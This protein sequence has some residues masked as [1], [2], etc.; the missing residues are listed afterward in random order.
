MLHKLTFTFL[1]FSKLMPLGISAKNGAEVKYSYMDS[2][3]DFGAGGSGGGFCGLR[4]MEF[5]FRVSVDFLGGG[6][7]CWGIGF[8]IEPKR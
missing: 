8:E 3:F 7:T 5:W 1:S 2:E 6:W 4:T